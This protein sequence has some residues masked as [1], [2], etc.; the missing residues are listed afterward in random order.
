MS[1]KRKIDAQGM[2]FHEQWENYCKFVSQGEKT[3]CLLCYEA[4]SVV[5][6]FNLRRHFDI[7][8]ELNTESVI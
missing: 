3:V 4:V 7:N 1:K 8:M 2:Q 5:K 6:E